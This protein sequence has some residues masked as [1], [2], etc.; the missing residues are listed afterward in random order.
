MPSGDSA[1]DPIQ[2]AQEEALQQLRALLNGLTMAELRAAAKRWRWPLRGSA[3]ADVVEQMVQRL[4]DAETMQRIVLAMPS[5]QRD[6][7]AWLSVLGYDN[8][9]PDR[10]QSAMSVA[11]GSALSVDTVRELIGDLVEGCLVFSNNYGIYQVPLAYDAWM[12]AAEARGLLRS[13]PPASKLMTRADLLQHV[14]VLLTTI[15]AETPLTQTT[16]SLPA[17]REL[18]QRQDEYVPQPSLVAP[19][20]LARWGFGHTD[21]VQLVR[22][23]LELLINGGLVQVEPAANQR[24]RLAPGPMR[25][26][27]DQVDPATRLGYLR[28]VAFG[29]G[30][31]ATRCLGSWN[32]LNMAL[33]HIEGF[34]LR[35]MYFSGPVTPA[36]FTS[37]INLMRVAVF[38][39][40]GV[41]QTGVWYD[42]D[43][44]EML[45]FQTMRDPFFMG[46]RLTNFYVRWH[47]KD[48][49]IDAK[50]MSER[51]WRQT[52]GQ[53]LRAI[54]QGPA[55]WLQLVELGMNGTEVVA[56]RLPAT[57]VVGETARPPGDALGFAEN[58][59]VL[60]RTSRWMGDLR[61]LAL[62]I[63]V[64]AA[65][66]PDVKVF[67]LDPAALRATL[68]RGLSVAD[69]AGRFAEAGFPLPRA[70]LHTLEAW[71]AHAGRHHL[72]DDMAAIE[73]G[74]DVL[75]AEIQAIA[76]LLG[77]PVFQAS[78]H[79]LLLLDATKAPLLAAELSR[80]G[81]T[82]KVLP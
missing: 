26:Q 50:H 52:Y 17:G 23:L 8:R 79:C 73:L 70:F 42:L 45:L 66:R 59:Y 21:D 25:A 28:A 6:V 71:Q 43:R 64:E 44:L 15:D 67:K 80:R 54:L 18:R 10:M 20:L 62:L 30:P 24:T 40:V 48:K 82:P 32:E 77:I 51:L 74:D 58:Q 72:Y 65:Q 35:I 16:P 39:L 53:V 63:A 81:Y 78:P 36:L 29:H 31:N 2:Q 22:F 69:V 34:T 60:V 9:S 76:Q 33:P 49:P 56:V 13:A 61:R 68:R 11:S 19:D 46:Q 1:A 5:E 57:P 47:D 27:W 37:I 12:P 55:L 41:L 14:D 7:L 75:Q 4:T 38:N 3:K